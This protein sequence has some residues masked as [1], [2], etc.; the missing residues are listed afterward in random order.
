[1]TVVM[2]YCHYRHS[3]DISS[4]DI[5]IPSPLSNMAAGADDQLPDGIKAFAYGLL[6]NAVV[7][8]VFCAK[9]N[10]SKHFC[11]YIYIHIYTYTYI[12]MC[13]YSK[14]IQ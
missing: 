13:V 4:A 11:I 12:Y 9:K 6:G 8:K 14:T 2:V 3:A 7:Q 1:M 5:A 10:I